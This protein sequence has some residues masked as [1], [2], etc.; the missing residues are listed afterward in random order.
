MKNTIGTMVK[1]METRGRVT[2]RSKEDI[3]QILDFVSSIIPDSVSGYDTGNV[4]GIKYSE[5]NGSNIFNGEGRGYFGI[6]NGDACLKCKLYTSDE[7]EVSIGDITYIELKE[8][9]QAMKEF[10]ETISDITT[11]EG[12]TLRFFEDVADLSVK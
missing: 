3:K 9:A 4:F 5:W 12:E 10:L 6:S 1:R 2:E 7:T 11:W 8:A